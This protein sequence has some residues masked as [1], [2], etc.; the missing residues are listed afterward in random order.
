MM[1]V[2]WRVPQE[3]NTVLKCASD[4]SPLATRPS[5]DNI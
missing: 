3:P 1:H 5:L 2:E 4:N